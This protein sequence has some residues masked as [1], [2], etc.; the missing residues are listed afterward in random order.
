MFVASEGARIHS[1]ISLRLY[2]P[3]TTAATSVSSQLAPP[4]PTSTTTLLLLPTLQQTIGVY[5]T[6]TFAYNIHA[7][8]SHFPAMVEISD[9][10]ANVMSA[11]QNIVHQVQAIASRGIEQVDSVAEIINS[12]ALSM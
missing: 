6:D 10:I 12:R 5:T 9:A 2:R 4:T 1:A 3:T 7:V 11:S 8:A